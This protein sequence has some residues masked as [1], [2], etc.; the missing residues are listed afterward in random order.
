M[1]FFYYT[2]DNRIDFHKKQQYQSYMREFVKKQSWLSQ[3]AR[4]KSKLSKGPS[5]DPLVYDAMETSQRST[6]GS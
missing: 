2:K 3:M 1:N 5:T 6:L 4:A